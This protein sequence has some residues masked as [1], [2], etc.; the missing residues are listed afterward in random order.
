MLGASFQDPLDLSAAP[1][2]FHLQND[3]PLL[4]YVMNC[5][6]DIKNLDSKQ[7]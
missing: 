6:G 4:D 1:V 3:R 7:V 2:L 5:D